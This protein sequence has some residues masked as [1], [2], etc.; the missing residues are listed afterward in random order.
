MGG[1]IDDIFDR[2]DRGGWDFLQ[3][4]SL[5]EGDE[6]DYVDGR[7]AKEQEGICDLYT[8]PEGLHESS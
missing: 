2:F 1:A 6:L 5:A 4:A 8:N 7:S 3:Q